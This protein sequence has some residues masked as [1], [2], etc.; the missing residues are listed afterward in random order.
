MKIRKGLL[1]RHIGK[2]HVIIAPD[3]GVVD[4]TR[5]YSL[6]DCAAWLWEQVN[7]T[8]FTAEQMEKLLMQQYEVSQKQAHADVLTLIDTLRNQ[9]M[10]EE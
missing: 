1:L 2:E 5:V 9:G 10:I 3:K 4:M 7:E 6:N 8:D